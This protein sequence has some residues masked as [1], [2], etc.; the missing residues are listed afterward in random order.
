MTITFN[1]ADG[2]SFRF[3]DKDARYAHHQYLDPKCDLIYMSGES[4]IYI[5][6]RHIT[7]V[8]VSD[9]SEE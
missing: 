3:E 5:V 1:T 6:K 9:W 2:K 4:E 7:S 8:V